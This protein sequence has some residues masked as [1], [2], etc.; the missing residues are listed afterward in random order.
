MLDCEGSSEPGVL[1]ADSEWFGLFVK[2]V[3]EHLAPC[4]MLP[5]ASVPKV[6]SQ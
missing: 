2:Q 4:E 3:K 1:L 6:L 5:L